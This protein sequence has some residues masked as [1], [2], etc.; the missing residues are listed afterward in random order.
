[1]EPILPNDVDMDDD[2]GIALD[3]TEDI[4]TSMPEDPPDM[5]ETVNENFLDPKEPKLSQEVREQLIQARKEILGISQ[6]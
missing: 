6:Q 5:L 1:M 3:A 2:L 4:G